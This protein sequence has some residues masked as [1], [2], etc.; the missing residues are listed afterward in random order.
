MA[1][2]SD[3]FDGIGTASTG[4]A[5]LEATTP[6]R[7]AAP[8]APAMKH[9]TPFFSHSSIHS[10]NRSGERCADNARASQA[11]PKSLSCWAA[12]FITSQSLVLPITIPTEIL[13][14]FVLLRNDK[15]SAHFSVSAC[16]GDHAR[17]G[18]WRTTSTKQ[19]GAG[20][21]PAATLDCRRLALL[22]KFHSGTG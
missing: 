18:F 15:R 3:W 14:T 20:A 9:C 1:G 4:S 19:T 5:V 22:L 21:K 17:A 12:C 10:I 7:C 13:P 2:F 6:A 16:A 11:T 8:P